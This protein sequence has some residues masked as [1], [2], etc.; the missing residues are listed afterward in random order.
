[1]AVWHWIVIS[2]NNECTTLVH[3]TAMLLCTSKPRRSY[4]S[5]EVWSFQKIDIRLLGSLSQM[6]H[7]LTN[8][9][10]K[11]WP[12][13]KRFLMT[14]SVLSCWVSVPHPLSKILPTAGPGWA[15]FDYSGDILTQSGTLANLFTVNKI[16]SPELTLNWREQG[17]HGE[18]I[19]RKMVKGLPSLSS[20]PSC[21]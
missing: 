8:N 7:M 16:I 19:K 1:M 2:L 4:N 10:I 11:L 17:S 5:S 6:I 21:H 18:H 20:D 15:E 14:W 3:N 9:R 12:P 13:F